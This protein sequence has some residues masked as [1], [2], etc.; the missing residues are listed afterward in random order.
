MTLPLLCI[1]AL[2]AVAVLV[3][4]SGTATGGWLSVTATGATCNVLD[5]GA[6]GNGIADDTK[7]VQAAIDKCSDNGMVVLP[8][9]H[10]FLTFALSA[11]KPDNFIIS[12]E[13]ELLFSNDTTKWNT[14]ILFCLTI[15]GGSNVALTGGGLVNGNGAAWWPNK[16]GYRPGLVKAEEVSSLL[17]TGLTFKD[18]P[19]HQ[20][21][22]FLPFKKICCM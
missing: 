17:V 1:V 7:A 19:N 18:S 11:T 2:A 10:T 15:T 5:F 20:V 9:G 13:G 4:S 16:D 3:E 8:A 22:F 21:A 6:V 14:A 12:V